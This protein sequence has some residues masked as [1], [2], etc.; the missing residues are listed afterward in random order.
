MLIIQARVS[1][2]K[3]KD[4]EG[5]HSPRKSRCLDFVFHQNFRQCLEKKV[6]HLIYGTIDLL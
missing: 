2:S 4:R 1:P 3:R 5:E 6:D